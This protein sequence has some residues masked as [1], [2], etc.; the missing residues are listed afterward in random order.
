MKS[1]LDK[2]MA[3]EGLDALLVLGESQHNPAMVYFTGNAHLTDA[4][5][6]KPRGQAE[7]LFSNPM[8]RDEAAKTGLATRD[9]GAFLYEDLLAEAGGDPLGAQALRLQKVLAQA[10]VTGGRVS[11]YGKTDLGPALAVLDRLQALVP[12]LSLVGELDNPVLLQAMATKGPTEVARIREMGSITVG[13]VSRVA[14]FLSSQRVSNDALVASD[15]SPLT[16]G[17]V[18]RQINLWLAQAGVENPAG[19]IFAQGRDAGI[20]H[21]AGDSQAQ[22]RLGQ[23]IVFDIFPT[24]AGGGYFYDFTRTWCLGYAPDEVL[25]VYEDVLAVYLQVMDEL[26]AGKPCRQYQL[27]TCELFEARGHRT[28]CS[29]PQTRDGYVHSLGHGLGLYVHERP[30][31]GQAAT[32]ADRLDP[33]VVV[34]IEPGLYY[35]ERGL[36]VR[37]EDTVY[38]RPDGQMEVLADFPLDLVIPVKS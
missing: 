7:L 24:E 31:F 8:E 13:V 30:R 6:V 29:Q 35:P 15:G 18:K 34:T 37:L 10:G 27:R 11:V 3:A 20:P 38:V 21:S 26:E 36:G 33:G 19:T 22:I 28:L 17:A 4:F 23:T 2:L 1:D 14:E 32:P 9:L 12:G 5:L 25:S 16:I